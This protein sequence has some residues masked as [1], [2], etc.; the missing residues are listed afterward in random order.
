MT[1]ITDFT[2]NQAATLFYEAYYDQEGSVF[3]LKGKDITL[4]NGRTIPSL[5]RLYLE[6]MDPTEYDFATKYFPEGGWAQWEAV[7]ECRVAKEHV[8]QWRRELEVK[9][10]AKALKEII[11]VADE[12]G[13]SAYDAN[14]YLLS[15]QWRPQ[16]EVEAG[17]RGRPSKEEIKQATKIQVDLD[18]RLEEDF[19]RLQISEIN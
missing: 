17:K 16:K 15:G 19:K 2:P 3:T 18:K 4:P 14:K 12:G 8:A 13:K 5:K 9:L 10:R 11:T 1:E 6:M 7:A